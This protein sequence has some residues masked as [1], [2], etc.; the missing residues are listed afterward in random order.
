MRGLLLGSLAALASAL[1][2]QAQ[3]PAMAPQPP[4]S[5]AAA[6]LPPSTQP[7]LRMPG[8][9]GK[10][11]IPNA[12]LILPPP[13]APGSPLDKA[14][15]EIY[16]ATRKF[17]GTPRGDLAARDA[18]QYVQA[19]DCPLGIK[20]ESGPPE[21]GRLFLRVGRDASAITNLAKD[22]FKRDRPFIKPNGPICT[23]SDRAGLMKS[24]SYPSGH[25]TYSWAM[26]LILA[27]IAPDKASEIL[28]RARAFGESRVVCG[29]HNVS[30]VDEGRTNGSV[31][32]AAL[33]ANPEFRADLE[34]AKTALA[35]AR[36]APHTAPDAGECKIEADAEAHTP[37]INPTEGK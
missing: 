7:A 6:S 27:E 23:E 5:P 32:V 15:A 10:D 25:T 36:A 19:F 22:H 2:V 1:A 21:L 28:A 18:V 16:A 20:L 30:D 31:L 17:A 9:L 29:V 11:G 24:Y 3:T 37:W 4:A 35:A 34:A 14:D 33:H 8:Y 12:I 26:G 13:P